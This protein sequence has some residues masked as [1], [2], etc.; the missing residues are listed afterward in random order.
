MDGFSD[1]FS[2][3]FF[4]HFPQWRGRLPSSQ[5]ENIKNFAQLITNNQE[6]QT[7][8]HALENNPF[9]L[10][11]FNQQISALI[12]SPLKKR[13]GWMVMLWAAS[14]FMC[15]TIAMFFRHN[16][17]AEIF[18]IIALILGIFGA[19][20]KNSCQVYF[21]PDGTVKKEIEQ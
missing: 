19:C 14:I 15:L 12:N 8:W 9:L 17:P 11:Y 13:P 5:Q 20:L 1:I 16:L 10:A 18:N 2:S 3:Y 21:S 6:C 7:V 4:K